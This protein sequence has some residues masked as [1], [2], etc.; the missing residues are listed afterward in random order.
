MAVGTFI[1]G[2]DTGETPESVKRKRAIAAMLGQSAAGRA[3]RNVGEGLTT[4]GQA[5]AFRMAQSKANKA[6]AAGIAG[7]G[8]TMPELWP[9]TQAVTTE[10]DMAMGEGASSA[11]EAS[12][13]F[14]APQEDPAMVTAPDMPIDP[15]EAFDGMHMQESMAPAEPPPVAMGPDASMP[16]EPAPMDVRPPVAGGPAA[17]PVATPP[18]AG[19]QQVAGALPSIPDLIKASSDPW[20]NDSQR[21]VVDALL[22]VQLKQYDPTTALEVKKLQLQVRGQEIENAMA[23]A[24]GPLELAKLQADA[25]KIAM[26]I[27]KLQQ[28]DM[29]A[30]S[31]GVLTREL[32]GQPNFQSLPQPPTTAMQENEYARENPDFIENQIRLKEAG[33]NR[34]TM[35]V[36]GN[37]IPLPTLE[38]GLA[39]RRGPDGNVMLDDNGFPIAGPYQ[40][41]SAAAEDEAA[42]AQ[43]INQAREDLTKGQR[44][45]TITSKIRNLMDEAWTPTTGTMSI[46]PGLFSGTNAGKVRSMLGTV[47]SSVALQT[48]AALKSLSANGSTGFGA[49]SK[50][51]LDLLLNAFGPLDPNFTDETIIRD[52][53][54]TVD[55]AWEAVIEDVR[56][57]VTPEELA[58]EGLSWILDPEAAA[59]AMVTPGAPAAGGN[60]AS[61]Q[62]MAIPL[63]YLSNMP[64]NISPKVAQK[65][66][67]LL[68]PEAQ[69]YWSSRQ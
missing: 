55:K 57:K 45:T 27:I 2:G 35:T 9:Q 65:S 58:K 23:Q 38:K 51:E 12:A 42:Q 34:N 24:K 46:V 30:T 32:G 48:I 5:I 59:N 63:G 67:E 36:G 10:L 8:E 64:P 40:G 1:F 47:Q 7:A 3:P 52:T 62:S 49:L 20:L 17:A 43:T 16:T 21:G 13:P 68:S 41:G 19:V 56:R 29:T 18:S 31:G 39:W 6:E 26:E 15:V 4:L 69:A 60:P 66:W 61:P 54:D 22:S 50:P 53:L 28:G 37:E 14:I 11:P 33:A 44:I 25:Q